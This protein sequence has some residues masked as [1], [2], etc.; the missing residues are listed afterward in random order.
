M[1]FSS[2]IHCTLISVKTY[3]CQIYQV[4]VVKFSNSN[5]HWFPRF[6]QHEAYS[7]FCCRCV[8]IPAAVVKFF[9]NNFA[10]KNKKIKNYFG[11]NIK[12]QPHDVLES[13]DALQGYSSNWNS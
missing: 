7:F 1:I 3:P 12:T 2:C 8:I 10:L 11:Q 9:E 13:S 4:H 5:I 6:Y